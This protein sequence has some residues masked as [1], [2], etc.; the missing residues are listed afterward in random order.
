PGKVVAARQLERDQTLN[1]RHSLGNWL[2][3]VLALEASDAERV[4]VSSAASDKQNPK[5][6]K[7]LASF[8]IPRSFLVAENGDV[9]KATERYEATLAWRKET[10]AD[11][12]LTMPQTHYDT[13]KTHYTQFLHKHD[14]LGHPL[15]FEKIGSI[16]I[17]QLKKA[18]IAQEDLFRHY[19]F[20]ME[21]TLKY[22][23]HELCQCDACATSDTQKLCIVLDARGIGMRDMGGEAFEFIRKCTGVMQR[24]YPQ[25]SFK[26]FFVNVPSWFGM[27]WKG[28]KPLLNEATRAKTN[29]L[30]ESETAAALLEFIDAENLPV[31]YGGSCSCPGGCAT[32]SA[33]Q[34]LQKALVESVLE[35]K[36]FESDE[37]VRTISRERSGDCRS[38]GEEQVAE[39]PPPMSPP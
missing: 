12:I 39:A 11:S 32:N 6:P 18:G 3:S 20:A 15:Y 1:A 13:I 24:H 36:P 30:T 10:M 14:K 25:R 33:Y 5:E 27:A 23:A 37:L 31:E 28:V 19:L 9:A 7:K 17:G 22:A 38:S 4:E 2:F 16:N 34:L 29:I 8:K 26:I 35:C 21:F